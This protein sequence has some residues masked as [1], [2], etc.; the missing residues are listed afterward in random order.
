M[1][2]YCI[3]TF[4]ENENE[5]SQ[6]PTYERDHMKCRWSMVPM[7]YGVISHES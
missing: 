3:I 7:G 5:N 2:W 1:I 4:H 6:Q